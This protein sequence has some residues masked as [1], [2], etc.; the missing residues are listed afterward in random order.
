M[1]NFL[2]AAGLT[3]MKPAGSAGVFIKM[4]NQG[5]T[6][7]QQE[8]NPINAEVLRGLVVAID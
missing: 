6:K 3:S 4:I 7:D 1:M 5:S 8:I 2:I